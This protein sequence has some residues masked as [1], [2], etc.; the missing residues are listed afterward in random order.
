M[1]ARNSDGKDERYMFLSL[2]ICPIL[3]I[4]DISATLHAEA[5][6]ARLFSLATVASVTR[7]T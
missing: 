4:V 3:L 2:N 5:F 1:T 7:N 6:R